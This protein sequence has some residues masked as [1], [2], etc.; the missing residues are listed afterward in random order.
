[1]AVDIAAT[2]NEIAAW[3]VLDQIELLHQAWDAVYGMTKSENDAKIV[4]P[5]QN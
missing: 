4:G 5:L 2:L 3:P 1:M